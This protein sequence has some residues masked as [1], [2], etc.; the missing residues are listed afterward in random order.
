L[1][2]PEYNFCVCDRQTLLQSISAITADYRA[3]QIAA[4]TPAHVDTW[5]RQFQQFNFDEQHQLIILGE[6]ERILKRFY[7]SRETAIRFVQG[8]IANQQI[9]GADPRAG[10]AGTKFLRIQRKGNS[11][12]ELLDLM[13]EAVEEQYGFSLD[14]CGENPTRYLYFDD[15]IYSGN[16]IAHNLDDW[17]PQANQG[18][19]VTTLTFALHSIGISRLYRVKQKFLREKGI[20]L[21]CRAPR[22]LQLKNNPSRDGNFSE[23]Y[24][25]REIAGFNEANEYVAE[26]RRRR[27]GQQPGPRLFRPNGNPYREEIF[28]SAD[29]RDNIEYAFL[30]AGLHIMS[31]PQNANQHMRP[32]GYEYL[33]S[34]GFGALPVFYRNISNNAPLALWWGDPNE[35]YPL[36]QWRPLFLRRPNEPG[37]LPIIM[38][39]LEP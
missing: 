35:G 22:A 6:M 20:Q 18:V 37:C 19:P 25:P 39:E 27:D 30:R 12:N 5:V 14:D 3:G 38:P 33:E 32:M 21:E 2:I 15:C 28:S 17:F 23:C 29:A 24:W 16:T 10:V 36:N 26:L 31:L 11:Q 34:L 8:I 7:I 13:A 1:K 4:I 9:F